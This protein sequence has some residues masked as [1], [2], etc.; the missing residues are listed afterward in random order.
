VASYNGAI[1]PSASSTRHSWRKL[2][3]SI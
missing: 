1:K 2:L 3:K